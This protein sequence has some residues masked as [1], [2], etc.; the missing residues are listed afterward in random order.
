[1][2]TQTPNGASAPTQDEAERLRTAVDL[3][4]EAG[5]AVSKIVLEPSLPAAG[6]GPAIVTCCPLD[7]TG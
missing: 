5:R 6:Q 4:L 7:G 2:S 1:M 3:S